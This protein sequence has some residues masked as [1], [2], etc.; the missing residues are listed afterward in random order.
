MP[1]LHDNPRMISSIFL[2]TNLNFIS[3]KTSMDAFLSR[4][5]NG[6]CGFLGSPTAPLSS[7]LQGG[8]KWVKITAFQDGHHSFSLLAKSKKEHGYLYIQASFWKLQLVFSFF[9][10]FCR[11]CDTFPLPQIVPSAR[12]EAPE[13]KTRDSDSDIVKSTSKNGAHFN[14]LTRP[15]LDILCFCQPPR[16]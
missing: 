3:T 7:N 15:A 13:N 8:T 4:H 10:F 14:T 9:C 2:A 16:T 1:P 6:I 11:L 12:N 5:I